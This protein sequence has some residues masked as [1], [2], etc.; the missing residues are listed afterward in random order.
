MLAVFP[1]EE[2]T[3]RNTGAALLHLAFRL[4]PDGTLLRH[5]LA[6]AVSGGVM[7]ILGE[8]PAAD[9]AD[10]AEEI[11]AACASAGHMGVFL[12]HDRSD[13]GAAALCAALVSRLEPEGRKLYVRPPLART[14]A[15]AIFS[16]RVTGG[17]FS[18]Y[19]DEL[20]ERY[21]GN[22]GLELTPLSA[23][24]SLPGDGRGRPLSRE[25]LAQRLARYGT[26]YRSAELAARYLPYPEE[27]SGTRLLLWD[28]GASL[29]EKLRLA[30]AAGVRHFLLPAGQL[31][32]SLQTLLCNA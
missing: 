1:Q 23:E 14:D 13:P 27:G 31:G 3:Y 32:D 21:P 17:S 4:G 19:L 10:M 12:D 16:S 15:V 26:G 7:G 22:I 24:F 8:I 2:E 30:R 25:E 18:R 6:D 20:P 29:S 5:R 28:D 9:P 11:A